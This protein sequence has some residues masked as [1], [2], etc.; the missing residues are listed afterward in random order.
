MAQLGR[1]GCMV[2]ALL[3]ATLAAASGESL[4]AARC[5]HNGGGNPQALQSLNALL[6]REPGNDA[7]YLA[8]AR[9]L[10][11]TGNYAAATRD[12]SEAIRRAPGQAEAYLVRAKAGKMLGQISRAM[13]DYSAAI[14][15]QPTAEA[16]YGRALTYLWE[17]RG[18][19]REALD[20]FT[21]A[22]RLDPRYV[23]A[24]KSRAVI[25]ARFDQFQNALQDSLT[26]LKLDPATP[27]A[28]CNVGFAHYAL[29]HDAEGR[30]YLDTCYR[31]DPD[32]QTRGYYE[33]EVRKVLAA[34]K[35]RS[36]GGGYASG[37]R[38]TTVVDRDNER[39]QRAYES[40]RN[41]GFEGRAE[42]CRTDSN[43]C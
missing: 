31:K 34:R 25:Y 4:G 11:Y 21:T 36:V 23:G 28:Y 6:A 35:P 19:E 12:A 38:E 33:T 17:Y 15:L 3:G 14:R 24:Y 20:D 1:R 16:Y 10:Y 9:C 13:N 7:A 42:A 27:N 29:G 37:G 30:R 40:L 26:V 41:S 39:Q 32:P 18:K 2:V 5:E 22:I 43:K 8:R